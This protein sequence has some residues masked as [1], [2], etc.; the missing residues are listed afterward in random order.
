MEKQIFI[1]EVM[2]RQKQTWQGQLYWIKGNKKISFR[3][4][5][6]MLHL[7]NSVIADDGEG[8]KPE[9]E[10]GAKEQRR[11]QEKC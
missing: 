5:T 9:A 10:K 2:D 4:V 7:M 3:S 1:V 6:E 11:G 8:W